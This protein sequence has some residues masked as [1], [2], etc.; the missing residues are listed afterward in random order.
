MDKSLVMLAAC[1][2][3]LGGCKKDDAVTTPA[4]PQDAIVGTWLQEGAN[5][6]LGLRAAPLKVVKAVATFNA[7]LTVTTVTTD[8]SNATYT[9]SGGTYVASTATADTSIRSIVITYSSPAIVQTGIFQ[10][11]GTTM[12]FEAVQTTPQI[13]GVTPPTIA[14]GFGSSAYNGVKFGVYYVQKFVKQ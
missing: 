14:A 9:Y 2:A 13:T 6:A 8:S 7:N 12:T 1:V 4:A 10:I 3:L 5:V 11:K